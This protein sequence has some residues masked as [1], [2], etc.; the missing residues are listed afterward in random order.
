MQQKTKIYIA[1]SSIVFLLIAGMT[2]YHYTEKWS[3]FDSFYFTGVTIT[4][5]GYGDLVP[6]ITISK[7]G[8]LALAFFGVAVVLYSL[9]L[10]AS[11]YF[12]HREKVLLER[13]EVTMDEH[14]KKV[15]SGAATSVRGT[16]GTIKQK[17]LAT[18]GA[19]RHEIRRR[20]KDKP[21]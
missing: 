18:A 17:G 16:A 15:L 7:I 13:N 11:S 12:E 4:T 19:I 1:L 9:T 6:T 21:E 2:F 10:I 14:L 8:T 5:I 3:W 20:L